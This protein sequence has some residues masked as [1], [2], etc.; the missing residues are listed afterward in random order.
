MYDRFFC[1]LRRLCAVNEKNKKKT[2]SGSIPLPHH[3][4]VTPSDA[5]IAPSVG[6]CR[7]VPPGTSVAPKHRWE[8]V[9]HPPPARPA[10]EAVYD[11]CR[12]GQVLYRV[13]D[14]HF[15]RLKILS[16]EIISDFKVQ[17]FRKSV[18]VANKSLK[19]ETHKAC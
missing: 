3:S 12:G 4:L 13:V 6:A 9:T 7:R 17:D 5:L 15:M 19:P 14:W 1:L 16:L 8:C 2:T 11:L 18:F 10:F